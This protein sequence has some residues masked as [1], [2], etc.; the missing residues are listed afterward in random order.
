MIPKRD[1]EWFAIDYYSN[2]VEDAGKFQEYYNGHLL[3]DDEDFSDDYVDEEEEGDY[4]S[5]GCSD[6]CCPCDGNKIGIP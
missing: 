4:D 3:M 6:P 1:S 2:T 5:C